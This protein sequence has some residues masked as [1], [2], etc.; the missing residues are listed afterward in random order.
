M[1]RLVKLSGVS[2]TFNEPIPLVLKN[3]FLLTLISLI[4]RTFYFHFPVSMYCNSYLRIKHFDFIYTKDNAFLLKIFSL[5][6]TF[7]MTSFC[8]NTSNEASLLGSPKYLYTTSTSLYVQL[9]E[10]HFFISMGLLR[11]ILVPQVYGLNI[12]PSSSVRQLTL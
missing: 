3:S 1:K 11:T 2:S 9:V 7:P 6:F 5:V 4:Y 8:Q 10:K 12:E